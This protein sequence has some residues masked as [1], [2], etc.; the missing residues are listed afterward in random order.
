MPSY[1]GGQR[2]AAA[3]QLNQSIHSNLTNLQD[4]NESLFTVIDEIEN[5]TASQGPQTATLQAKS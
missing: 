3:D 4:F 2:G 5:E 1:P